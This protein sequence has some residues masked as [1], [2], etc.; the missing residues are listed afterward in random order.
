MSTSPARYW[1]HEC[2]AMKRI[3]VFTIDD[4]IFGA[5]TAFVHDIIPPGPL[6]K[7]PQRTEQYFGNVAQLE[8]SR[9]IHVINTEKLLGLENLP[10]GAASRLIVVQAPSFTMGLLV[11]KVIKLV[12]TGSDALRP[13]LPITGIRSDF[14]KGIVTDQET[15][16]IILDM[17]M[18]VQTL[19][20]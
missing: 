10:I 18:I 2:D 13:N 9:F 1:Q 5:D 6:L 8:D 16:I 20:S 19:G 12:D 17:D 14:L 15:V 11:D 3:A 7:I 4:C